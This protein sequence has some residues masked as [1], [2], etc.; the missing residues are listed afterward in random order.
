MGHVNLAVPKMSS[1]VPRCPEER[2]KGENHDGSAC[3]PPGSGTVCRRTGFRASGL[4][5]GL[6]IAKRI[7][8]L[9]QAGFTGTSPPG[10]PSSALPRPRHAE[11]D[12]S[13]HRGEPHR[14]PDRSSA[15]SATA[16]AAL[17][18]RNAGIMCS[19]KSR[20]TVCWQSAEGSRLSPLNPTRSIERMWVMI[21]SGSPARQ[22][23]RIVSGVM[24]QRS[25]G[26]RRC[27]ARRGSGGSARAAEDYNRRRASRSPPRC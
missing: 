26:C 4:Q 3:R 11:Q 17:L 8:V 20:Y 15:K 18:Q 21:S 7:A 23:P 22:V 12:R 27:C 1:A 13:R 16:S 2:Q 5:Y 19:A 6:R 10:H 9:L 25:P 24:K 14:H